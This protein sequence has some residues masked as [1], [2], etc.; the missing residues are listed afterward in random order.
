MLKKKVIVFFA[1]DFLSGWFS[2]FGGCLEGFLRVYIV[3]SDVEAEQVIK[4]DPNGE[5][6]NLSND[7]YLVETVDYANKL[8]DFNHDRFLRL[9]SSSKTPMVVQSCVNLMLDIESQFDVSIYLDEPIANFPNYYFN[10]KF[11]SAGTLCLHFQSS[12]LPGYSFFCSDAAQAEPVRL[13]AISIGEDLVLSHLKQREVGKGRPLY[14]LS[15]DHFY[16][17]LFD[18]VKYFLKGIIKKATRSNGYYLLRSHDSDFFHAR[19]LFGSLLGGYEDVS[20]FLGKES[21]FVIYPM[22]YEPE[23]ILT[24]FSKYSRQQEVV[25]QIIDSLPIG[26]ELIIKEHPSQPGA[27]NTRVWRDITKCKRV[28]KVFGTHRIDFL[29]KIPGI[30]VV[31]FGSTMALEAALHGAKC[32]VFGDVHFVNAPGI[33]RIENVTDWI[34]CIDSIAV[35]REDIADWYSSFLDSY[36]FEDVPMSGRVSSGET[37]RIIRSLQPKV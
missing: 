5:I 23:N 4:N 12:W 28:H 27:L 35:S 6:F 36:C 31:S 19:C 15:Y 7:K 32:A 8:L 18:S 22:H 25:A 20:A 24:Y 33:V 2:N 34:R 13:D 16:H 10:K 37:E 14:V 26:Y 3:T 29:L 1:R 21:K 9:E 11:K 30:V 17:R